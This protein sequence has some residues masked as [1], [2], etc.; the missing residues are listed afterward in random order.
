MC[1]ISGIISQI[2]DY[3]EAAHLKPILASMITRGPD[4]TEI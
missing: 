1:A 4:Q 2:P 3:H